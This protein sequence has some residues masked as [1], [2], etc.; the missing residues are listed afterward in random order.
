M[1]VNDSTVTLKINIKRQPTEETC[2]PTCLQAVY[3]Y[4]EDKIG[5]DQVI[6]EVQQLQSGGTLGVLLGTHALSRG[7]HVT[8]YTYNLHM[9]DPTWFNGEI[10]VYNKLEEQ[11]KHKTSKRFQFAS[12][13][14]LNYIEQGGEIMFR[15]L[16]S[17]LISHYL[18]QQIPVLTGLSATYLYQSAREVGETNSY[19][20]VRGEPAGHFI[21]VNGYEKESKSVL[22]ADPYTPNP[23]MD[24]HFYKVKTQRLL[25]AILLGVITYDANLL[26]IQPKESNA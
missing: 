13:A 2:G 6:K 8:I 12:K 23:F 26:I 5:L 22:I 20:D 25:N 19:D 4:F 15:E 14:Y 17:S 16:N 3:N 11:M 7:Y 24:G 10:S 18:T 1:L 21:V 9:F